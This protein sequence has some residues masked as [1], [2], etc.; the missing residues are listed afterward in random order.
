MRIKTIES[1]TFESGAKVD[2]SSEDIMKETKHILEA[3]TDAVMSRERTR[4]VHALVA[5]CQKCNEGRGCCP[6]ATEFVDCPLHHSADQET[7]SPTAAE[8][9]MF[10]SGVHEGRKLS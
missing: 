6:L 3:L 5:E 4:I 7:C 9:Q 10:L 1:I 2:F 8:W